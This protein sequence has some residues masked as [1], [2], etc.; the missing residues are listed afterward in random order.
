MTWKP[1][2]WYITIISRKW[3][4]YICLNKIFWKMTQ[5]HYNV[6]RYMYLACNSDIH[7]TLFIHTVIHTDTTVINPVWTWV[8]GDYSIIQQLNSELSYHQMVRVAFYVH[9]RSHHH[10][11]HHVPLL[12]DRSPRPPALIIVIQP[13]GP[14]QGQFPRA[15]KIKKGCRKR[16]HPFLGPLGVSCPFLSF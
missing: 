14:A 2:R 6:Y 5:S 15:Q 10:H 7:C 1:L 4:L 9:V 11:H 13:L 3:I 16:P 12:R 8:T